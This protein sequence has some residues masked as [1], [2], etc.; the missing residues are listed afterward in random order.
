MSAL[1]EAWDALDDDLAFGHLAEVPDGGTVDE[2]LADRMLR[3]VLR[4]RRLLA[5]DEEVVQAEKERLD[6]WLAR[7]RVQRDTTYLEACLRQFH[8]ARLAQDRK[9]KTL[10]LPSG[11]LVA[12]KK[13][14][15]WDINDEQFIP[16]AQTHRADLLRIKVEVDRAAVKA[17]LVVNDDGRVLDMDT[18]EFLDSV[19][20]TPGDVTFTIKGDDE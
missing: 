19:T 10:H 2:L 20:V 9:A 5:A 16:W 15:A 3:R 6:E 18:G 7:R 4:E 14:A 8:E 1:S 11:T 17:A 12:R 13:P